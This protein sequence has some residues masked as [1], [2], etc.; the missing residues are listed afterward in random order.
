MLQEEYHC[1][2]YPFLSE[3]SRDPAQC[4]LSSILVLGITR[5]TFLVFPFHS[6]C[7]YAELLG[8]VFDQK[9]ARAGEKRHTRANEKYLQHAWIKK[10]PR[11]V[12]VQ[13]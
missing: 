5:Y 3:V 4:A 8:R 6:I 7:I 12:S 13:F 9:G 10:I 2:P 1:F 11:S